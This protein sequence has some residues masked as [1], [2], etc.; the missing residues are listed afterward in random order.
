RWHYRFEQTVPSEDVR[1]EFP[2]LA[3]QIRRHYDKQAKK[4]E[5]YFTFPP[6]HVMWFEREFTAGIDRLL[7]EDT[8]AFL[9]E[10]NPKYEPQP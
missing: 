5:N 2:Q 9:K 7:R 8:T 4:E 3:S 10:I 1:H 6:E